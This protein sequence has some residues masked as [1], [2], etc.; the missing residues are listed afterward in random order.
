MRH[1]IYGNNRQ[2]MG[3][4]GNDRTLDLIVM[5]QVKREVK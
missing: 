4:E 2:L 1:S 5:Q 3:E